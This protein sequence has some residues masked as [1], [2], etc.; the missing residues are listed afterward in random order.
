MAKF[1]MS[2]ARLEQHD[3]CS[4]AKRRFIQAFGRGKVPVTKDNWMKASKERLNVGWVFYRRYGWNILANIKWHRD[5]WGACIINWYA[6]ED[7]WG[8]IK[9]TERIDDYGNPTS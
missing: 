8:H 3:A 1:Y 4:P 6:D 9:R 7:M 5:R 2:V